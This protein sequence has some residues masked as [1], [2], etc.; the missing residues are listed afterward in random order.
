MTRRLW[1]LFQNNASEH[2]GRP[3]ECWC[4]TDAWSPD[5]RMLGPRRTA[6]IHP[7]QSCRQ[8]CDI[9]PGCDS[10]TFRGIVG[11]KV[12]I[13]KH[14]SQ[15]AN[16]LYFIVRSMTQS[17]QV[18]CQCP[19]E[20][21]SSTS[22][23][24][25]PLIRPSDQCRFVVDILRSQ[26]DFVTGVDGWQR[27]I[28]PILTWQLSRGLRGAGVW[29]PVASDWR[30][31]KYKPH[32]LNFRNHLGTR[33]LPGLKWMVSATKTGDWT[34][35]QDILT[36][37]HVF[38]TNNLTLEYRQIDLNVSSLTS[39]P[40]K[41]EVPVR[42]IYI[43]IFRFQKTTQIQLLLFCLFTF[44]IMGP[45]RIGEKRFDGVPGGASPNWYKLLYKSFIVAVYLKQTPN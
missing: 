36:R 38:S 29:I 33:G 7:S 18:G 25:Q 23:I 20:S 35:E 27:K 13:M 40:W 44:H 16:P 42:Y 5:W 30:S 8:S 4:R 9:S 10:H 3:A 24:Q 17:V 2:Q 6:S 28:R 41:P 26:K 11:L 39:Y 22:N 19:T 15:F 31:W 12:R 32:L 45:S 34:S 1:W 43:H 37:D 14:C 21:S